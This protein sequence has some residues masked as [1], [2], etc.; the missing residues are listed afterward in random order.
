MSRK[1]GQSDWPT[2]LDRPAPPG[3][4]SLIDATRPRRN[5][6][7]KAWQEW[8]CDAVAALPPVGEARR[9]ADAGTP[10]PKG[11]ISG[12]HPRAVFPREAALTRR[13]GGSLCRSVAPKWGPC[14]ARTCRDRYSRSRCRGRPNLG[15]VL[16]WEHLPALHEMHFDHVRLVET[17]SWGWRVELTKAPGRRDG[18]RLWSCG[19]TG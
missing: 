5:G 17:G 6:Q 15:N 12:L 4:L 10:A 3:V 13:F 8:P 1:G 14:L 16:D 7:P 19:S 11:E 18:G 2:P 9:R